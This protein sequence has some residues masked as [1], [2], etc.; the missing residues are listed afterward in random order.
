MLHFFFFEGFPYYYVTILTAPKSVISPR[1]PPTFSD[2]VT[3]YDVFLFGSRPL[4]LNNFYHK[5]Q[6]AIF[7]VGPIEFRQCG[8]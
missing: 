5:I 1:P 2:N 7:F 4:V 3:E 8:W 6:C